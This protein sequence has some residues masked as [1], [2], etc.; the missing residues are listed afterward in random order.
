MVVMWLIGLNALV[1]NIFVLC[2]RKSKSDESKVQNFLLSNLAVSDLLMGVYMLLIASADI[3]FGKYFP[4]HADTWRSG[5][6]CRIAGTIAIVSSEASVFFITLISVDRF[7][8]IKYH[9][10]GRKLGQISSVV[11]AGVLWIM[12]LLLGIVPSSLAGKN[13]NFYDNAHVCIGLPLSKLQ[14]YKTE[15]SEEQILVCDG[16]DICVYEQLVQS[17]YVGEVNGSIFASVMFLGLNFICYLIILSCY[18]EIIRTVFKSSKRAGLHPQMKEQIRLTA[19]VAAIVLTD[20]ASWFPIIVIGILVQ[21]GV[22]TLPADVFA[23]CVAF[24]LPI[25][26]AI[27]PYLYTIAA[28]INRRLKRARIAPV[29][30]Q[31]DDTNRASSRREQMCQLRNTQDTELMGAISHSPRHTQSRSSTEQYRGDD[32]LP[33]MSKTAE[34]NS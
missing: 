22:L 2:Q 23:W 4:M 21:A 31:Q 34:S 24:V 16:D 5:F 14:I 27:N 17:E 3:Y 19:K 9:N 11:V 25:N 12:A 29:E 26:S 32:M 10:Y 28:T 20:F 8:S 6:T 7:V 13:Y 33:G 30:N 15:E 18:V 1:G